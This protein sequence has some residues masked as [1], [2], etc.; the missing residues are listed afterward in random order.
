MQVFFNIITILGFIL[1]FVGTYL[2]IMSDKTVELISEGLTRWF[3]LGM[4]ITT[5]A[6]YNYYHK[7]FIAKSVIEGRKEL[8]QV[9]IKA[10]NLNRGNNF[11]S[12]DKSLKE[13]SI[14]CQHISK[15]LRRF[16]SSE[17]SVCIHYVNKIDGKDC[18]EVL[19]RNTDSEY[20]RSKF[21]KNSTKPD[22]INRN[23]DFKYIFL[24][25]QDD[26][27]Q[28]H[29]ISNFAAWNPFYE[30]SH[31]P[32]FHT[33]HNWLRLFAKWPLPYK[34]AVVV[35][36]KIPNTTQSKILGFL[37]VDSDKTYAFSKKYDVQILM[38]MADSLSSPLNQFA[39]R[40]LLHQKKEKSNG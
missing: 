2:T 36:I 30:N 26:N 17:I 22:L 25:L 16:H 7:Y 19:A 15:G 32:N 27:S 28:A 13:F 11:S 20:K 21:H 10:Q 37:S 31:L 24:Q 9:Q 5:V 23:S 33:K 12:L 29:Y 18:V 34:S 8:Q 4:M 3:I 14:L 35:P 38:E 40:H 6:W 39:E 1:T